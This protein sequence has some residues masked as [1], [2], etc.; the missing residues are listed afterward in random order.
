MKNLLPIHITFSL[1][2][3]SGCSDKKKDTVSNGTNIQNRIDKK[4]PQGNYVLPIDIRGLEVGI[5]FIKMQKL[6]G[7]YIRKVLVLD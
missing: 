3:I 4:L 6:E 2:F 7:N 5:Y 1:I